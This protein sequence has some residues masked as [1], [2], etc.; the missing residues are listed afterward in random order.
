MSIGNENIHQRGDIPEIVKLPNNRIRVVRRFQKFNREDVDNANLG[1]LMGDFGALDTTDEQITNQGYTNCRLISVEVDTRFN[2]QA[3]ADN[4]VLVKTYETLTDSFVEITDPLVEFAENGL[5]KITKV[6]RAKSG[7]TSSNTVGTT[8]LPTTAEILA[9]SKIEDNTALAELTE[10]YLEKGTISESI[11]KV[12]SQQ[13]I[14]RET[15]GSD[16]I[17][18]TGYSVAS[19]DES[20]FEGYQTNRFTFL[21]SLI[22]I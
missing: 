1:S 19:K 5:K 11:E 22:H 9:S 12:G 8:A 21:L 14:V 13:A 15:I 20:N 10:I 18:P 7:T 3:N 4:A 16:P 2:S 17:T 6:Y